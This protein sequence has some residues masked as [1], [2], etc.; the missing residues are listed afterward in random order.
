SAASS[1]FIETMAL[2]LVSRT[3]RYLPSRYE[4]SIRSAELRQ[5]FSFYNSPSLPTIPR[6]NILIE[7][8][9]HMTTSVL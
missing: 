8:K 6:R 3:F 7:I 5:H 4:A 2:L 1:F 9:T